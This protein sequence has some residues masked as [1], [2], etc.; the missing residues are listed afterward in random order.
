MNKCCVSFSPI[1]LVIM[2]LLVEQ[3]VDMGR[4]YVRAHG[5]KR[6]EFPPAAD[7][8]RCTAFAGE[9]EGPIRLNGAQCK[10]P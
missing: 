7:P 10:A 1:L 4:A 5:R 8:S 3:V 2:T 6:D 9:E